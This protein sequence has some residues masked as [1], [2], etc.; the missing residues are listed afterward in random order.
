M[1]NA[2][3]GHDL[4]VQSV[5]GSL[6]LCI[7]GTMVCITSV[8]NFSLAAS[9]ALAFGF[10]FPFKAQRTSSGLLLRILRHSYLS[11]FSPMGIVCVASVLFGRDVVRGVIIQTLW[12][13][14]VLRVWTLPFICCVY[15]PLIL[16]AQIAALLK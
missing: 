16:Q 12:N 5:L 11:M 6:T 8:L 4:R 10:A 14:N 3:T 7:A 2:F 9:L 15:T 1:F 13:W